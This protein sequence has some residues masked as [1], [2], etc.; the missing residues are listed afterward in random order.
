MTEQTMTAGRGS[1][2]A[3]LNRSLT[4]LLPPG[5]DAGDRAY[6]RDLVL[7]GGAFFVLTVI[8]YAVTISWTS[9]IPRDGTS[10]AVGRDFLNFWMYGR[11]AASGNPGAFYDIAIYHA[12]IRDLLGFELNGQ[13]WSYPPSIMLLAAPFGQLNYLIALSIWTAASIVI[14]TVVARR[15]VADWRVLVPVLIS[16][17][18]LM[19]L[20]SGQSSFLTAALLIASFAWL[21]RR[22][23]AAG[24]LIGL[25]TLKPQLGLLFPFLLVASG[26]WR[27]FAAASVTAVALAAA[28]AA[29][30]GPQVWIDFV[31]KGLPVQGLVLADPDRIATP[32]FPTV[33]M[34]LRGVDAAYSLAMSIQ[35]VFSVFAIGAVVWAARYRRD[36]DAAMMFALFL[37]CSVSAS[38]YLLSYDILPLTFAAVALLAAGRLDYWG[39]QLAQ[40]VFW[41]PVLQLVLGTYH[42]PGASLIAPAFAAYLV[43]RLKKAPGP[44]PAP[45]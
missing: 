44:C 31:S 36:A 26:R 29:V 39:R 19:C 35:A 11:A 43:W 17:A 38:P 32:F 4:K 2:G 14:F 27:V 12:A 20:I 13:N 40:L 3:R 6:F 34:N 22:P 8:A 24:I 15:Y 41:M 9:T 16:P 25:L 45:A 1:I 18:A 30:F 28:T 10:L 23:L 21:D 5:L 33:F 42:V 7:L 37:A